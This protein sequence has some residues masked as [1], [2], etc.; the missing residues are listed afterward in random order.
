MKLKKDHLQALFDAIN[1][2]LSV[3]E[4]KSAFAKAS[5]S[6]EML[7]PAYYNLF[8]SRSHVVTH[9]NFDLAYAK[10]GIV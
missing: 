2:S 1:S 6:V 9:K 8:G 7:N 10:A 5:N 3:K 4:Q